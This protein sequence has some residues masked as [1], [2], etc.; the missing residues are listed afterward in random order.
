MTQGPSPLVKP[1]LVVICGPTGVGKSELAIEV[2]LRHDGE[3]ISADSRQVYRFMDIGTAKPTPEQRALVPHHLLD[4]VNPD[5]SYSVARYC[6]Q[7][8][9]AIT[10]VA[11]RGK[12]PLVVGGTGLYIRALMWGL[13]DT[14]GTNRDLRNRL[15]E[16]EAAR[17]GCLYQRLMLEDPGT[18]GR[19]SEGDLIRIVRALEVLA[20]T[21]R[22]ISQL[23]DEHAFNTQ[24]YE[25]LLIGIIMTR[26]ELYDRIE[27]R[28][29]EMF[30][31]GLVAEV[32]DLLTKG[33]QEQS[34]AMSGVGYRQVAALLRGELT[35]EQA[36]SLIKRDTRRYAK[37]QLTWFKKE[38]GLIWVHRT[39]TQ[40]V[41]SLAD[42]VDNLIKP[43]LTQG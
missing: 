40:T 33:Y 19:I 16:A 14:P 37:R 1:R 20:A 28:V 12:L 38:R 31:A 36:Q 34:N 8:S 35:E 41:Q 39:A 24:N 25:C 32:N 22:P 4:L 9:A 7:A 3:I 23:H 6:E 13:L 42:N 5:E 18:A 21:Q 11:A 15:L 27:R 30:R 29:E 26:L 10:E 2:A 17:P 43:M